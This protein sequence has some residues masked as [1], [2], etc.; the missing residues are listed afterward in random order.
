MK[1]VRKRKREIQLL[2]LVAIM[3]VLAPGNTIIQIYNWFIP[4]NHISIVPPTAAIHH[5][6]FSPSFFRFIYSRVYLHFDL[7]FQHLKSPRHICFQVA[8]LEI[9]SSVFRANCSFFVNERAK[10]RFTCFFERTSLSLFFK[11]LHEQINRGRSFVK[12]DGSES[13]KSL[14]KKELM[15]KQR[16]EGFALGHNKGEI[17]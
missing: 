11:E 7:T 17:C 8:G 5:L 10:V 1:M 14:F 15:C 16:Y 9:C 3:L 4:A 13:L 6:S 2:G 12:S